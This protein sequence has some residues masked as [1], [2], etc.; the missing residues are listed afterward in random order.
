MYKKS[1]QGKLLV[2]N[3]NNPVDELGKSLILLVMHGRDRAV[4]LQINNP[5]EDINLAMVSNNIGIDIDTEEPLWFG[6]G[7]GNNKI[8]VVHSSDWQGMSTIKINN[9]ISVTND[10][11]VLAAISQNE[12]PAQYRACAGFWVWEDGQFNKEIKAKN[13]NEV[14]HCWEA[15]EA[16]TELVFNNEGPDQWIVALE[17]ST[18]QQVSQWF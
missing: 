18:K 4:G 14:L 1:Y 13:Y 15:T 6:G 11:S 12:G 8:H 10:I 7:V 16:T 9:D 17:E 3:P 2:S 5:L